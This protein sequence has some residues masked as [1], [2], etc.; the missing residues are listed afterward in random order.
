MMYALCFAFLCAGFGAGIHYAF[1]LIE[2]EGD[3]A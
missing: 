1:Y 2:R 3:D